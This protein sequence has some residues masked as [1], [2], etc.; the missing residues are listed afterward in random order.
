MASFRA[1][2]AYTTQTYVPTTWTMTNTT[3]TTGQWN[4]IS[5][6]MNTY[7]QPAP[8]PVD[9]V[10]RDLDFRRDYASDFIDIGMRMSVSERSLANASIAMDQFKDAVEHSMQAALSYAL[11]GGSPLDGIRKREAPPLA[12]NKFINASDMLEE[13]IMFLGT[14]NVKSHQVMDL[15][16]ELFIKWLVIR[17]CE[18]DGEE[19]NVT[20]E[21]P[22]PEDVPR[23]TVCKRFMRKQPVMI[24][25]PRCFELYQLRPTSAITAGVT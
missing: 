11:A 22:A 7:Q 10:M 13:F 20:L 4:Y 3:T 17:A 19:P 2:N 6:S 24:D 5:P 21:L 25:R 1:S 14:E 8:A 12:F 23:C 15:P 9:I 18:A 16:V